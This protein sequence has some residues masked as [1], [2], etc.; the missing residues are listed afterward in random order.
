MA[1]YPTV[2]LEG[3]QE[4]PVEEMRARLAE[5]YADISRRRTV[6]EFSNRV[7]LKRWQRHCRIIRHSVSF[8][9]RRF[10]GHRINHAPLVRV[11]LRH[12]MS[13]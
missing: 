2:P 6:R 4:Y 13:T 1:D 5:F 11:I 3:F 10:F 7:F 8:D 12:R 9:G